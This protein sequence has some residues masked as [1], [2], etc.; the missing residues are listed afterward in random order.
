[1]S[2][3]YSKYAK[4]D[5]IAW[6]RGAD[7]NAELGVTFHQSQVKDA[8]ADTLLQCMELL[9]KYDLGC[10]EVT[11]PVLQEPAS[12]LRTVQTL[13]IALVSL[14]MLPRWKCYSHWRC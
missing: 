2:H 11:I 5:S 4:R 13:L 3:R 14:G 10:T 8:F 1:M 9:G 6:K 7:L 12:T